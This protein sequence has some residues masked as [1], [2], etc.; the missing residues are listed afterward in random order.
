M[1]RMFTTVLAFAVMGGA[2]SYADAILISDDF[3]SGSV[4]NH[5][6]FRPNQ[7]DTWG[8]FSSTLWNVSGETMNNAATATDR[9][10]EGGMGQVI[11][12]SDKTTDTSLTKLS[13]SFDYVVGTGS[14]L[15]LHLVGYKTNGSPDAGEILA[16][17]GATG[18]SIQNQAETDYA[19]MNLKDG[20]DPTGAPGNAIAFTGSGTYSHTF[21]LTAYTWSAD[22]APGVSGSIGSVVDFDLILAA[23]AANVTVTDGTGAISVDNFTLEAVPEPAVLSF[24]AIFGGG[25]L[26]SRRLFKF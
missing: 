11:K 2:A 26:V 21:D 19:D 16:N 18:G 4:A 15:Y 12:V 3:T 6:R 17:T 9:D 1:K 20:S 5:N 8:G 24:I 25:L 22:E 7:L 10:G 14:T 23:F 13:L